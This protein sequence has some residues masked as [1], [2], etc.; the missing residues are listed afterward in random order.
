MKKK[1]ICVFLV[2]LLSLSFCACGMDRSTQEI[3]VRPG[4]S[5]A[6]PNGEDGV[7]QDKDGII[8]NESAGT[9]SPSPSPTSMPEESPKVTTLPTAAPSA[10]P[11]P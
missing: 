1:V 7:V 5:T 10:S 9:V 2:L 6:A 3:E 8:G 4:T 11:K